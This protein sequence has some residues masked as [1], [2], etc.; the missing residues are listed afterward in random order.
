MNHKILKKLAKSDKYQMLYNQAK[1]IGTLKLFSNGNDLSE[2]QLWI[3]YYLALYNSLY[4]DLASGEEFINEEVI[5]DNLRTEAYLLLRKQKR[6]EKNPKNKRQVATS[7]DLPSVIFR[8][9][10]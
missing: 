3:L 1:E 2:I 9:K 5:K 10:N 4:R 7:G 8:E 6:S